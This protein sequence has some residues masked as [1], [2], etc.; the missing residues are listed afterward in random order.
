MSM[1]NPFQNKPVRFAAGVMIYPSATSAEDRIRRVA[2]FGIRECR[3]A[4]KLSGLQKTV[5]IAIE[6]R[7]RKVGR[8]A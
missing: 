2:E 1:R 8:D 4:L 6:R 5:R 7:L 3:A